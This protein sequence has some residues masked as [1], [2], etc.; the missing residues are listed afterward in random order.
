MLACLVL[1]FVACARV[2]N[3][4]SAQTTAPSTATASTASSKPATVLL[5]EPAAN[6]Q[7]Y[8]RPLQDTDLLYRSDMD[9]F[10]IETS[11]RAVD[12]PITVEEYETFRNKYPNYIPKH[13]YNSLSRHQQPSATFLFDASITHVDVMEALGVESLPEEPKNM[14]KEAQRI[15]RR[16]RVNQL[17]AY[18]RTLRKHFDHSPSEEVGVKLIKALASASQLGSLN[19]TTTLGELYLI[20][21]V[22]APNYEYAH[23]FFRIGAEHGDVDAHVW[24]G[25]IYAKGLVAPPP[26]DVPFPSKKQSFS[27][28]L[29][30]DFDFRN[31]SPN[32]PL[33]SPFRGLSK[34]RI[35]LA[36]THWFAAAAAGSNEAKLIL[37]ARYFTGRDVP[38]SCFSSASYYVEVAEHVMRME[39]PLFKPL[40]TLRTSDAPPRLITDR[41]GGGGGGFLHASGVPSGTPEEGDSL[42]HVVEFHIQKLEGRQVYT[43]IAD[44]LTDEDSSDVTAHGFRFWRAVNRAISSVVRTLTGGPSASL[45]Q[46]AD[47]KAQESHDTLEDDETEPITEEDLAADDSIAAYLGAGHD[48]SAR[49]AFAKAYDISVSDMETLHV[50]GL[51][52][53]YGARGVPINRRLALRCLR[54]AADAGHVDSLGTLVTHYFRVNRKPQPHD[55]IALLALGKELFDGDVEKLAASGE[56]ELSSPAAVALGLLYTHG[57]S[58]TIDHHKPQRPASLLGPS[59]AELIAQQLL[60][61]GDI[62]TSAPK[63]AITTVT[64]KPSQAVA[65][66]C[67]KF[68]AIMNDPVGKYYLANTALTATDVSLDDVRTWYAEAARAGHLP[69]TYNLAQLHFHGVGTAQSCDLAA[70]LYRIVAESGQTPTWLVNRAYEALTTRRN[71]HAAIIYYALAAEMGLEVAQANLAAL[72]S[73]SSKAY[74]S[75]L[76]DSVATGAFSAFSQT[77]QELGAEITANALPHLFEAIPRFKDEFEK[78]VAQETDESDDSAQGLR[79]V[80]FP[81]GSLNTFAVIDVS[82]EVTSARTWGEGYVRLAIRDPD[83]EAVT[84]LEMAY[85][86]MDLAALQGN[87]VAL[88]TLGDLAFYGHITQMIPFRV[89]E[90][91]LDTIEVDE[92]NSH[93]DTRLRELKSRIIEAVKRQGHPWVLL[94]GVPDF[95]LAAEYYQSASKYNDV[96]STYNLGRLEE[97]GL[98]RSALSL[99]RYGLPAVVAV[100]QVTDASSNVVSYALYWANQVLSEIAHMI[101]KAVGSSSPASEAVKTAGAYDLGPQF[102]VESMEGAKQYYTKCYTYEPELWGPAYFALGRMWVKAKWSGMKQ[103]LSPANV[104]R[105]SKETWTNAR[106]WATNFGEGV[107]SVVNQTLG[108]SGAAPTAFGQF[109]DEHEDTILGTLIVVFLT[110]VYFYSRRR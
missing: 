99:V 29:T 64:I 69:S 9:K 38:R 71:P 40:G 2:S 53:Y 74:I 17:L 109:L 56:L 12:A 79:A 8:S 41:N 1:I 24:L 101:T 77:P 67:F 55:V 75:H 48:P 34:K 50:L 32:S 97:L 15:W 66:V 46:P 21:E 61:S 7:R 18:A 63:E 26:P 3:A 89:P 59:P 35:D 72:L 25:F 90:S 100:R 39:A 60:E 78:D 81:D 98:K 68:A 33:L 110:L 28:N 80:S 91:W 13:R 52:Y 5:T 10:R 42:A 65:L 76:V 54:I 45:H 108:R 47:Q 14:P 102:F 22:V 82:G 23:A 104:V 96:Q 94:S 107:I 93:L 62:Q 83:E 88:R 106:S 19:A 57:Y 70:P 36:L 6:P 27:P 37:A 4:Q 95:K 49:E 87:I 84:R 44:Y 31:V 103:T 73:P 58:V 86:A 16:Y 43:L 105:V 92:K 51:V 30:A 11:P 20:G 85:H